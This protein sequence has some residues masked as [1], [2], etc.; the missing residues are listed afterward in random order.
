MRV[1]VVIA[2]PRKPSGEVTS[3]V[4]AETSQDN[5]LWMEQR[6]ASSERFVSDAR[7]ER[8]LSLMVSAVGAWTMR[9]GGLNVAVEVW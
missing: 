5:G 3:V 6:Q 9:E 7:E 4:R 1:Y 2:G 8:L